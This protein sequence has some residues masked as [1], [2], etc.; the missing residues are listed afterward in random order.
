MNHKRPP[1]PVIVVLALVLLTAGYFVLRS[2]T[3]D[4]DGAL[5]ASGTIETVQVALAP[6][7]GGKV[8]EVYVGEGDPVS[9][10][11]PLFRL[12]DTLL[13][14]QRTVSAANLDAAHA[15]LATALTQYDLAL[16]AAQA[17]SAAARTALWNAPN[18][19]AYGLPGWYFGQDEQV[20]AAQGQVE[21]AR[22][23]RDEAQSALD[24][25][26][27]DPANAEAAAA[28]RRLLA[29]RAA[30]L[31]AQDAFNRTLLAS[32]NAD[33]RDSAQAASDAA[34]DE[35]D[36]AQAAYDLLSDSDAALALRAARADLASAQERLASASDRL[37]ALQTGMQSLRLKAGEA[38]VNQAYQT[39][40]QTE[41][42]LEL[43]D[44]QLGKLTV[45]AP[46][47]G[48]ILTRAVEPGEV[49]MA[50]ARLLTLGRLDSLTITV[51]VPE[52]RYGELSLGQAASVTVDSFPGESFEAS[53]VQ[54]AGQA[55][56]TPRNVQTV[57]GRSGT[58]YAVRLQVA[59]PDGKLKPGMPAD[60]VFAE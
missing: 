17:E 57:E 14:A 32:D 22:Q 28:E 45:S 4:G 58:V 24:A 27:A 34:R 48:V 21:L 31:S 29:A 19:S 40:A 25:L 41:A 7:I 15:A 20:A 50:G 51:Y 30:M 3:S 18:P 13:Q 26:L 39:I 60:V 44:V 56:F 2:L 59:D 10:G 35:L 53:V 38:A 37:L 1:I 5:A 52:D 46:A 47:D 6:E 42:A 49:V 16:A 12:D 11:D 43:I 33:L 9:A 8:A 54:I 36:D 23:T 55:E